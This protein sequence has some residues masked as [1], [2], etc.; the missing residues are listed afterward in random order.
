MPSQPT[1]I[2]SMGNIP[3]NK[4]PQGDLP[5]VS[6]ALLGYLQPLVY[7][8]VTKNN[9]GFQAVEVGA[10]VNFQGVVQPF[11]PKQL[12]MRPE[13]ERGWTWQTLTAQNWLELQVDDVVI[14]QGR[15]TRVM[16][17]KNCKIYGYIEFSL[18]Q[19]WSGSG[20]TP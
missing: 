4:Q 16:S 20:P 6:G 7:T 17:R 8:P 14:F 1:F 15:Q 10:P 11:T 18:L 2:Q 19:D 9:I 3:L 13:G 12:L 5:D